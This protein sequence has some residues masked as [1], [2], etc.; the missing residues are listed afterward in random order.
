[1]LC[2]VVYPGAHIQAG[3]NDEKKQHATVEWDN[4]TG[5]RIA[6]LGLDISTEQVP[7]RNLLPLKLEL[8]LKSTSRGPGEGVVW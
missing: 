6:N 5:T 1:M 7:R 4:S 3:P 2:P 8:D